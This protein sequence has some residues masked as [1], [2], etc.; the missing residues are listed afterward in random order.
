MKKQKD[1]LPWFINESLSADEKQ[2]VETWLQHNPEA[3]SLQNDTQRIA[4]AVTSQ[5]STAPDSLVKA[6]LFAKIRQAGE[7]RKS[8]DILQWAWSLPLAAV[9][10]VIILV[11]VQPV[12]QLQWSVRDDNLAAFRVYRAPAGGSTFELL[13]ELPAADGQT[14]YEFT[15]ETSYLPIKNYHYVIAIVAQNGSTAVS[16]TVSSN[17]LMTFASQFALLLTSFTLTFGMIT[18]VKELKISNNY[19]NIYNSQV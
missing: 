17:T 5:E 18:V 11:L 19:K 8:F 14:N 9:L 13:G 6:Q 1:L 12:T 16:P 10:I 15:D 2:M 7:N 4:S 3:Y